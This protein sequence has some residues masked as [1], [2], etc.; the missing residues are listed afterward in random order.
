MAHTG[1]L[2]LQTYHSTVTP[3]HLRMVYGCFHSATAEVSHHEA[4]PTA[5]RAENVYYL[6]IYR[7]SLLI[8]HLEGWPP[9]TLLYIS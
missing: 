2:C 3:I 7:T 4:D 1:L 6:A 8:P 5:Y 9:S